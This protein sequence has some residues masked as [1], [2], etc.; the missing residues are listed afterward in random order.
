MCIVRSGGAL[1]ESKP[2]DRRA[3][4]VLRKIHHCT[5]R[6]WKRIFGHRRAKKCVPESILLEKS[7]EYMCVRSYAYYMYAM[8]VC[9]MYLRSLNNHSDKPQDDAQLHIH[10][11]RRNASRL[12]LLYRSAKSVPDP[13]N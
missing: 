3:E 13:R 11:W 10:V 2:C 5:F 12:T 1:V 4:H 9:V 8:H 6:A 7:T